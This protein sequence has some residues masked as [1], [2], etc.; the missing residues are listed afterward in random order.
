MLGIVLIGVTVLI[1]AVALG[2]LM[3]CIERVRH[4]FFFK[5]PRFW[6]VPVLIFTVCGIFLA[7]LAEFL[8]WATFYV[9]TDNFDTMEAAA[10]YSTSCY[11]TL[12]YGD[13]VLD[14]K[15]RLLSS[16]EVANGMILFGWST[17]FI[18]EVMEKLY[19]GGLR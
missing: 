13:I 2:R 4:W 12:G 16:F 6:K 18:F 7:I 5:F 9:F 8:V 11:T 10:Y 17:A 14:P 19:G 15:W 1:H 3:A